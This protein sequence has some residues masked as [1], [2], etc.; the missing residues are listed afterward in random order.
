MRNGPTRCRQLD[1]ADSMPGKLDAAD[2]LL[3]TADANLKVKLYILALSWPGIELGGHRSV[4]V[5]AL[6]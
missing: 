5:S 6:F 4:I 1:A 3:D 2:C